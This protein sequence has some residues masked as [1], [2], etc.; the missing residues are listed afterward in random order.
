[1]DA[2]VCVAKNSVR[3]TGDFRTQ[4]FYGTEIVAAAFKSGSL[5][6]AD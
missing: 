5:V 3:H 1:M 2:C 6:S 4:I